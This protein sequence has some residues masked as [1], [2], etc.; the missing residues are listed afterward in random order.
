MPYLLGVDIGSGSTRTAV[1]RRASDLAGWGP[2]EPVRSDVPPAVGGLFRRCGDEVPVYTDELFVTPQALL[3]EQARAAADAVW[4]REQEGPERFALAYPTTWG[5]G[6]RGQL[7]AALDEAGMSDVVLMTRA[8]AV[9][10]RHRA[11]GRRLDEGRP[12][13]ICRIGGLGT[14]VS[15]VI[16]GEPGR[17]ELLA[18][19]EDTEVGGDDLAEGGPAEGRAVMAVVLDQLRRTARAGGADLADL[20]AVLL[21]GG[22]TTRPIVTEVL[23]EAVAAPVLRDDDPRQTIAC[24]AAASLRPP[25]TTPRRPAPQPLALPTDL[26]PALRAPAGPPLNG[27]AGPTSLAAAGPTS[28]GAAGP[29]SRGAAGPTSR[30]AAGPTVSGAAGPIVSGPADAAAGPGAPPPRPPLHVAGPEMRQR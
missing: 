18:A 2:P 7:R 26:V 3:V 20:A 1:C 5:A 21:A 27:A 19:T 29:T 8:R 14:E 11:I 4:A 13:A 22:G 9:V 15:V 10:E 23:A 25:S 28:R 12:V 6:R 17:L 30:G 24:G 16:P